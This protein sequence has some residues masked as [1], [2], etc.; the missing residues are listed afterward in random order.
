MKQYT[1]PEFDVTAYEVEDIITASGLTIGGDSN[2][3]IVGGNDG[4][5]DIA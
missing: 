3:V 5:H 2:G 4:W 1:A